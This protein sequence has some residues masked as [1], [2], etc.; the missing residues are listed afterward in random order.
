MRSE[1]RRHTSQQQNGMI[2]YHHNNNERPTNSKYKGKGQVPA[3]SDKM[4]CCIAGDRVMNE[5]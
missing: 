4:W 2:G 1:E 3:V 5:I